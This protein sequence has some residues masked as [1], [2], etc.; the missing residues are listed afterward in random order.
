M[1]MDKNSTRQNELQ[2]RTAGE[3]RKETEYSR[4]H[5]SKNQRQDPEREGYT[6]RM[7]KQN[8]TKNG[9]T[10]YSLSQCPRYNN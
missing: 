8:P 7:E 3:K 2:S 6:I 1:V 10:K 5:Q 9:D 4:E